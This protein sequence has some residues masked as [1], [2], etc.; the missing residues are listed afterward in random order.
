MLT[1]EAVSVRQIPKC[2]MRKVNLDGKVIYP[3]KIIIIAHVMKVMPPGS[4]N[5]FM[6]G[7]VK[8]AERQFEGG[9]N[10]M[11]SA[12]APLDD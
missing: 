4:G 6:T 10:Y 5:D 2:P 3:G 9:G 12:P 11:A 7:T 1:K 8:Q